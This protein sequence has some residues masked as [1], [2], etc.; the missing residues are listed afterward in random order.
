MAAD[1][2]SADPKGFVSSNLTPSALWRIL[3]CVP[4]PLYCPHME[5]Y[6][7][8]LVTWQVDEYQRV[9]RSTRWYLIAGIVAVALIV[10]A[11]ATANFLFAVIILMAG[12]VT[13]VTSFTAPRRIDVVVTDLGV[14]IGERFYEHKKIR[15]FS[16]AY[17]PPEVKILYLDF[18]SPFNP[19]LSVPLE[20]TDPNDVRDALLDYCQ[21]NLDRTEET[22]TD[23][24][25]RVY[26]L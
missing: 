15:D 20:E 12:I 3:V 25:R 4:Y 17:Q 18:T 9:E 22:L 8:P 14:A 16:I 21:E 26:K 24:M 19:L 6:G 13:L 7:T 2:K 11:V 23:R 5:D 1:L 10:Y